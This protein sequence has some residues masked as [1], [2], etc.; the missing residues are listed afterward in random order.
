[1][2]HAVPAHKSSTAAQRIDGWIPF[3]WTT[4]PRAVI[5]RATFEVRY[6]TGREQKLPFSA[7]EM[8]NWAGVIAYRLS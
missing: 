2:H 8:V 3:S 6:V 1:M 5:G 7:V 4:A